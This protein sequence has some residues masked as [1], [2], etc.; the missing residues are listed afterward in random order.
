MNGKVEKR[1]ISNCIDML[2]ASY[3]SALQEKRTDL[4]LP[5]LMQLQVHSYE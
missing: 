2:V 1:T 4:E 5:E 3:S